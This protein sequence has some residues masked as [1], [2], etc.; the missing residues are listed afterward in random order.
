MRDYT[1]ATRTKDYFQA[2]LLRDHPEIVSI[3]PQMKLDAQGCPTSEA[4]IVIGVKVRNPPRSGGVTGVSSKTAIPARLPVVDTRGNILTTDHVE[5]VIEDEGEIVPHLN[6]ARMRPCPGSFSVGHARVTAGMLGGN[7]R[8]GGSFGFI[9]SN[10][11]VLAAVNTGAVGDSILQPGV[12]DGDNAE[13]LHRLQRLEGSSAL[14][15]PIIPA[16]PAVAARG[17]YVAGAAAGH[18]RA[19]RGA[20]HRRL[21]GLHAGGVRAAGAGRGERVTQSHMR[22]GIG[23]CLESGLVFSRSGR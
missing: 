15:H 22:S 13:V 7:V 20:G 19:R 1:T 3:A 10:N 11:H 17:R 23:T 2:Q 21:V 14:R 4:V 5:V 12:A 8:F 9:L 18:R 6:A 16:G